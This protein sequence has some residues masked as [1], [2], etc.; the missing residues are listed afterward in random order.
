MCKPWL[1]ASLAISSIGLSASWHEN[2]L[3]GYE[4]RG[5]CEAKDNTSHSAPA[6]ARHT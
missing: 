3:N 4:T 5:R 1:L 2:S 6:R